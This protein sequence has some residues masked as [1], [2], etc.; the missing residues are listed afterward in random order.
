MEQQDVTTTKVTQK[1]QLCAS[2]LLLN[3]ISFTRWDNKTQPPDELSWDT[4][5]LN[6]LNFKLIILVYI[7][8][9]VHTIKL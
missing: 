6:L 8:K 3:L 2:K 1:Y 4:F 7:Y 9:S 5:F